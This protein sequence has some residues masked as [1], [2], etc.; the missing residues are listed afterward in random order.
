MPSAQ[1]EE[2]MMAHSIE[3][4]SPKG[5]KFIG[6]CMKC[7]R[8]GL[9]L[10]EAMEEECDNPSGMSQDEALLRTVSPPKKK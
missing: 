1:A 9:T 2:E 10:I 7:G 3:R 8:Q 5:E 6:T 4:T